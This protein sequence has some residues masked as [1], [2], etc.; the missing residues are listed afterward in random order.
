MMQILSPACA[1]SGTNQISPLEVKHKMRWAAIY[2]MFVKNSMWLWYE[3][4]SRNRDQYVSG[5]GCDEY[6]YFKS[7][8]GFVAERGHPTVKV[9]SSPQASSQSREPP[10]FI[11]NAKDFG[12]LKTPGAGAYIS[13]YSSGGFCSAPSLL[14]TR[15]LHATV[16]TSSSVGQGFLAILVS[17]IFMPSNSGCKSMRIDRTRGIWSTFSSSSHTTPRKDRMELITWG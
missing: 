7:S 1:L 11:V 4:I 9:F 6:R 15:V 3:C 14:P 13:V 8:S 17:S 12:N 10:L 16:V 2:L 5:S